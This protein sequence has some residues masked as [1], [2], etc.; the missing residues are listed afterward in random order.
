[1]KTIITELGL[2][3]YCNGCGEYWPLD[4]EFW[5]FKDGKPEYHC[6]GCIRDYN[7]KYKRKIRCTAH[8]KLVIE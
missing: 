8:L 5:Y 2:E 6:K 7:R 1:M 3:K 4:D